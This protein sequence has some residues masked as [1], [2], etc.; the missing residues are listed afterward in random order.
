MCPVCVLSTCNQTGDVTVVA[1][2]ES[3]RFGIWKEMSL[4]LRR[5]E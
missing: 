1:E 4:A 2:T 5:E 3:T